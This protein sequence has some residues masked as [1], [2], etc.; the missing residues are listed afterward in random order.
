MNAVKNRILYP[1]FEDKHFQKKISFKKEFNYQTKQIEKTCDSHTRFQLEPHQEFVKRFISYNTPYNGLLLFH[2]LGSGKTCSAIG[3]SE[4]IRKYNKNNPKF[5]KIIVIASPDVQNNFK[6]QLFDKNKLKKKNGI[7]ELSS[8]IGPLLLEELK[9][10]EIQNLEKDKI[11]QKINNLIKEKYV[12]MGYVQFSNIIENLT[13]FNTEVLKKKLKDKYEDSVIII[14]EAH[15][16][17]NGNFGE[18]EGKKVSTMFNRLFVNVKNIKLILLTGTPIYNNQA[19]IL[20]LLNILHTNDGRNKIDDKIIFNKD[21]K[22][23]EKGEEYFK[24]LLNGYVSRVRGENPYTFPHLVYPNEFDKK[25][26]FLLMNKPRYYFNKKPIPEEN[27]IKHLDL[28][29]YK[30]NEFQ[31]DS[32]NITIDEIKNTIDEGNERN[33]IN[34]TKSSKPIQALNIVYPGKDGNFLLGKEGFNYNLKKTTRKKIEYEYKNEDIFSYSNIGKYSIKIKN[35]IDCILNTEGIVLVYSN[36]KS[37]GVIPLAM[38]LEEI[39]FDRYGGP[40]NNLLKKEKSKK[41]NIHNLR[42][43]VNTS[44]FTQGHYSI[45]SGDKTYSPHNSEEIQGLTKDNLNG[46]KIKVVLITEAGTE[47]LDLNHIRQVHI[48]DPWW[49]MNRIEQ[50]IGRARRNCSH[51]YLPEEKRNVQVFLHA[52]IQDNYV[53]TLDTHYYRISEK[54]AIEIGKITRI[55][56]QMSVDCLLN[57]IDNTKAPT[58]IKLNLSN[59]VIIKNFD[60]RDKP[61]SPLCDYQDVCEYKC[62][63]DIKKKEYGTDD[64]TY[65]YEL[66]KNEYIIYDLKKLF[67]EKHIYRIPEIKKRYKN[68]NINPT[69]FELMIDSSIDYLLREQVIDKY[70]TKGKIIKIADLLLFQPDNINNEYISSYERM[71]IMQPKKS[72]VIDLE[73]TETN[74][75]EENIFLDDINEE[76]IMLQR[77]LE[78]YFNNIIFE[79]NI[80]INYKKMVIEHVFDYNLITLESKINLLNLLENKDKKNYKENEKILY[81]IYKKYM[82]GD[83][84]LLDNNEKLTMY[85]KDE[86]VWVLGDIEN[87]NAYKK[88]LINYDIDDYNYK[89][90]IDYSGQKK[91]KKKFKIMDISQKRQRAIKENEY[92]KI[93]EENVNFKDNI[94]YT[95][96]DYS[97]MIEFLMRTFYLNEK[98]FYYNKKDKIIFISKIENE[99]LSTKK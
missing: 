86:N 60:I 3:I 56:K 90:L 69:E 48:M 45:I 42:G 28:Y 67:S 22:F 49:N 21:G 1:T 8:C 54:K 30:M 36:Y 20:Y 59:G 70:G 43:N 74:D 24:A 17:R 78:S 76:I 13:S 16:I 68:K 93:I 97:F 7:W 40:K 38:A 50:I 84:I 18:G 79:D 77:K 75:N 29:V 6:L 95:I 55:I 27:T 91:D 25:F 2:G 73:I 35:I 32:Y 87:I 19:E 12:F 65:Q 61:Y 44:L 26:S 57:K 71:N 94:K 66:S 11:I 82:I 31:E 46:E 80:K 58:T 4:E 64:T 34:F 14:D 23:K 81:N 99:L 47:G 39:G 96:N 85:T 72:F 41:I 53:E 63:N 51:K 89:A 33:E 10:N 88:K 98:D 92:K 5:K 9:I 37:S 83:D 15:N 52:I 62:V